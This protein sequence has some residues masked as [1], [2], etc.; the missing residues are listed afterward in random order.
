MTIKKPSV[1]AALVD[2]HRWLTC[3]LLEEA[4]KTGYGLSHIEALRFITENGEPSMKDIASRLR[5]TPPSASALV[6]NLVEKKLVDRRQAKGDRRSTHIS[7]APAGRKLL[8]ILHRKKSTVL[9]RMLSKLGKED[10][11][12]LAEILMKCISN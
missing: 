10:K 1:D 12:R 6:D 11:D 2:F 7:L 4:R 3:S 9:K 5:I 8:L